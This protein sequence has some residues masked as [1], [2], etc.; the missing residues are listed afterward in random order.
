MYNQLV[1][2]D[3]NLIHSND[4][5]LTCGFTSKSIFK[6]KTFSVFW[7]Q[8]KAIKS[9]V[10]CRV[11]GLRENKDLSLTRSSCDINLPIRVN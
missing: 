4:K 10:L 1:I 2:F 8:K 3:Q 6:C 7:T 9:K 11:R 5:K